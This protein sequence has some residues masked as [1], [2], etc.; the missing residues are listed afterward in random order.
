M[1]RYS[2]PSVKE[3]EI[4]INSRNTDN[5]G[6]ILSNLVNRP[7]KMKDQMCASV[8]GFFA[9]ILY[10]TDDPQRSQAFATCYALS[11]KMIREGNCQYAWWDNKTYI[12]GSKEHKEYKN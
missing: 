5:R 7:F 9:G 8:E 10:K 2:V 3:T 4:N 11:Q 12:Y 1:S 6:R